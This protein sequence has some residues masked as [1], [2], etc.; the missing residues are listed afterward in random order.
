MGLGYNAVPP[1]YTSLFPP[2]KSDLS[3]TG[4][5]ELFNEPKTK[6][7]K[8][9]S[10][11][12]EPESV[13]KGSDAP[14]IE[15]WV[16]DDEE[17]N[18]EKRK[19]NL[20]LTGSILLKLQQIIILGRQFKTISNLNTTLI[21]KEEHLQDK[22]VIDSGCSR[23][24]TGNMSFLTDYKEINR[25]YV[26]FGGNPKGGKI[27]NKGKFD[28]KADNGFFVGYSL[29]S[30]AL[31]VINSRT[32]IVEE[33]LHVRSSENTPNHVGSGPNWLFDIN[34][35]TKIMN[36]QPI[37]AQSNDFLEDIGIFEDSHDDEDAFGAEADFHNLDSTFQV[38]PILTTRIHTDHPLEQVIGDMHSTPQTRRMSKNLEEHGLV[39]T[40]IPRKDNKDLQNF[41]F[42]C[43]L[44]QMEPKKVLQ[45]LKDTSWIESVQ[46]ELLQFKLQ[47]VWTLVN[48]PQG[49]RAIGSKWVFR[50]KMGKRGIVIR[51]KA[52][53][54]AQGHTQE[55]GIDYDEVF[56]PIARIEKKEGIFISQDKYVAEILKK[57]GFSDV[58]KASTPME[59]SKP[60]LKDKDG[61]EV[62]VH[63]YRSM[64]GSLMYL[65]SSRPNIMFAVYVCQPP[66]FENPDFPDKVYNVKKA[67]SGLH[68]AP[69]AWYE[70]LSTYLLDNRFKRG[71]IYKTLFIKRNK[72]D[73][74]LVQ[75]YVD[76]IIFGST[77]KEMYVKKASTPMETSKPL[78]KDEDGE[79]VDVHVYRSMISSLMYLT[80]SSPDIM[81]ACKKQ[82][83]VANSITEA[84]YVV[85]SKKP[86]E[87]DGFEQ[88]VDSLNANQIKYALT[89][90]PT[91]FTACVKQFWTTVKI[92]TI[93]DDVWL[94]ALIDGKKVVITEASIRYDLKLNDA[95]G[96]SCLPNAVI[97]EEL[98]RMGYEKPSEKLTFYKAFA[99]MMR[100]GTRAVTPLFD[101]MMVQAV[102][103]VGNLPTAIQDT[104]IPDAPSSSQPHRKHKPR[105]K[106]R[107]ETEVSPTEIHTED[108]VL[109]TSNDPL[110]SEMKSSHKAKIAEL[111]SRVEKLEEENRSLTKELKS[112]N[113][114][115]KSLIIKETIMDKE[116]SSKQGR[117]VVDIDADVEV[118]TSAKIIVDEVNT[119]GGALNAANEEP[120]SAAPTNITTAQPS[121][122]TMTT[123]DITTTPKAKG[124][125]FH[126]MEESTKRTASSKS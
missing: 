30:K 89:V 121:E 27:T 124:I 53:L 106:E 56:A 43:F 67:L 126:D 96:T 85:A 11:Y 28:G 92:K 35:L 88:I 97:F 22:G 69:R 61:E 95:E 57:F 23:H 2:P 9:K 15:D 50:N 117:K 20:V 52:R 120:V 102:E 66:G 18:V 107:K 37:V 16:S 81:F 100:V 13:R 40:V 79:E 26:A 110:P 31:R 91:I 48:L 105:R 38:S 75:V 63:L 72:G 6:K 41:L 5:E 55:E 10:N 1:P 29:N 54:V 77:K 119:A 94:Q 116:E 47:D 113:T 25:G 12:V 4:L 34:A 62:D 24:I 78:L 98:A 7:S 103:E 8:D 68:Q 65:T 125:V 39:G 3:Y 108:H 123:V 73:F 86:S 19:P 21:G 36:Y 76:D 74:L 59:T 99:N 33:N 58:K 45:A 70:T 17:E 82:T 51:N 80:S 122:A 101:T 49:K 93:N 84:E 83:V 32:R 115:V 46:E 87:I 111:E 112:F 104:P 42:A 14:I 44:S 109:T 64:I 114:R 90:S 60:L 71:Q 118:I